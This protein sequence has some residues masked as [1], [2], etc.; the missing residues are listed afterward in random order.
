MLVLIDYARMDPPDST[1]TLESASRSRARDEDATTVDALVVVWAADDPSR[2]GE[3]VLFPPASER[4]SFVIGRGEGDDG[5]HERA[6]LVRQRPGDT[7]GMPPLASTHLSRSQLVARSHPDGGVAL[8]NVGKRA[9]VVAGKTVDEGRARTGDLVE[10]GRQMVLLCVRRPRTFLPLRAPSGQLDFAFGA[11]DRFG[12]VGESPDAWTLR[13]DVALLAPRPEHVLVLGESGTGKELIAQALHALGPRAA[14]RF[15][16]RNAATVPSGVM[17]AELF[18]CAA[19]FPN[20]GMPER[21]GLVG[22]AQ[23]STLFLDEIGELPTDLQTHF[24]RLL[25]GGDYQ[26]LGDSR[27]RTADVRFV[28]ATNRPLEHL[29]S[30]LG[31]R[32]LSRV[33]A[34]GLHDR[35]EDVTLLVRHILRNMVDRG[36]AH[37]AR[38]VDASGEPRTS[39][40]LAVALVRHLYTTHVRE[41]AAILVCAALESR[42]DTVDLTEGARR[43]LRLSGGEGDVDPPRAAQSVSREDIVAALER[44]GGVR[45]KAWRDLKLPSRHALKRLMKKYGLLAGEDA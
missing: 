37:T 44:H 33:R 28:A 12:Y 29:K 6:R 26:R 2:I 22:E 11:S 19:N 1:T 17:D 21:L 32:F 8:Q 34:P 9:L 13:D 35:R 27:R 39:P 31:A 10:I 25:D 30:D 18:G 24:L 15:V 41:L 3:V 14:Q 16:A 20:A 45:D 40:E 36:D 23:G 7:L 43:M 42:G 4:R 38:F 5:V